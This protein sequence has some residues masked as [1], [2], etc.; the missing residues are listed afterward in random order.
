MLTFLIAI[1][2]L[3]TSTTTPANEL[4]DAIGSCGEGCCCDTGNWFVRAE[5]TFFRFHES[6]GVEDGD[7]DDASFDFNASPRVTLGY[8]NCSGMG[9]RVRWWDYDHNTRSVDNDLVSVDT[10]NIDFEL[11]QV[12]DMT[13]RTAVE[14]SGGIRYNDFYHFY[15]DGIAGT[16]EEHSFDGIGG[17]F[18]IEAR[19]SV[20]RNWSVYGR[21]RELIMMD[22]AVFDQSGRENDTTRLITEIALG[23]QYNRCNWS[24]HAGFE[25]QN[26][27]NYTSAGLL[28][29]DDEAHDVGFGGFVVGGELHY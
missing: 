16:N 20:F 24:A 1:L 15:Q 25:W 2:T 13:S 27:G 18:G 4:G 11:F 29:L 8:M 26:W 10:Y 28:N 22:D 12:F 6:A 23:I 9:A 3:S 21:L 7:G 14:I 17:M 19:A 5:A